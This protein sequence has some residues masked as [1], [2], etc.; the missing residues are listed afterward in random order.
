MVAGF[1]V[2]E[3]QSG[4]WVLGERGAEWWLGFG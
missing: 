2:R 4:G 3:G 1:W